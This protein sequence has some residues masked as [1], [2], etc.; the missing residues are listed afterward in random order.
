MSHISG[1]CWNEQLK[2]IASHQETN[3]GL[4]FK[5]MK[6]KHIWK[7]VSEILGF[8]SLHSFF[9]WLGENIKMKIQG[10]QLGILNTTQIWSS[11]KLSN[12]SLQS[13]VNWPKFRRGFNTDIKRHFKENLEKSHDTECNSKCL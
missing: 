2:T 7:V 3:L 13:Q 1:D 11:L 6:I 10:K 8:F 4:Y 12:L 9:L 5:R